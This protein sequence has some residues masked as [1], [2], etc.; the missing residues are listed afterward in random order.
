[1]PVHVIPQVTPLLLLKLRLAV[2]RHGEM[3]LAGWWNTKS[4]LGR[5]GRI[6]FSRGFPGTYYFAQARAVFAVASARSRE[7]FNPPASFTLW[8]LPPEQEETLD[9]QWA[10]W[11]RDPANVT[12]IFETVAGYS[13]GSLCDLL[14][15]LDVLD[16]SARSALSELQVSAQG[17]A[18]QLPGIGAPDDQ[19]LLLLAAAFS[20]G[21]KGSLV[22][23]YLRAE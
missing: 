17:K 16:A 5:V 9:S 11:C 22:V 10:S 3:D 4:V 14:S 20:L 15:S 7:V 18:V 19:A 6:G 8:N 21:S 23:P 1:M 2:A 12:P 13:G